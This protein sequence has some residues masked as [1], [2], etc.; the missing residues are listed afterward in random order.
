L[1]YLI[2][3]EKTGDHLP[4]VSRPVYADWGRVP[5][6][7]GAHSA[8]FPSRK[9]VVTLNGRSLRVVY[10]VRAALSFGVSTKKIYQKPVFSSNG[11]K[12]FVGK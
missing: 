4:E 2:Q 1:A 7:I 5:K 8:C 9:R 12:F 10:T 11:V 6:K 3:D